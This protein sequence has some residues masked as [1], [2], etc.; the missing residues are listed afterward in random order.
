MKTIK[1][2]SLQEIGAV[3]TEFIR[4]T[5]QKRL[6]ALYGEMGVGKTTFIKAVCKALKVED[7]VSSP[8]FSIVNEYHTSRNQTIYHFDFYRIKHIEEVY[9]FGYED[10]FYTQAICFMEWPEKIE[11]IL[12][13]ETL[14]L[15][16][17]EEENGSRSIHILES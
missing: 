10:Y 17:K 2:N 6:F 15:H 14:K 8:T 16:F 1:I 7:V 5:K 12:P 9:D 4:L 11:E 13:E 3:A